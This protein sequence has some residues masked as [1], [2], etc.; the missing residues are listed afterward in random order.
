M[1]D[2]EINKMFSETI[3]AIDKNREE[4]CL[5]TSID[6]ED[7]SQQIASSCDYDQL[8]KLIEYIDTHICD[9]EF[10]IR[11]YKHFKK[12]KDEFNK[13]CDEYGEIEEKIND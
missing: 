6:L 5:N 4:I 8:F 13:E 10:T 9:W 3:N 7:L 2:K 11:L 12:L 1:N